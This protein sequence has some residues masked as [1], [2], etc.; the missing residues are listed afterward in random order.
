MELNATNVEVIF[1]TIIGEAN[2][3]EIDLNGFRAFWNFV[4]QELNA[5][6]GA[7]DTELKPVASACARWQSSNR[8][9]CSNCVC[10]YRNSIITGTISQVESTLERAKTEAMNF[11]GTDLTPY[12]EEFMAKVIVKWQEEMQCN[13][14]TMISMSKTNEGFENSDLLC[15][16][17]VMPLI[18]PGKVPKKKGKP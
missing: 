2:N 9:F 3:G 18:T 15:D 5:T 10:E 11:Y 14:T 12:I 16:L 7:T 4:K 1:G 6:L 13:P 8:L 17:S